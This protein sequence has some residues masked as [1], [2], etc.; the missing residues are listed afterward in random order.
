MD[1]AQREELAEL[2][3]EINLTSLNDQTIPI[4]TTTL[5]RLIELERLDADWNA[6]FRVQRLGESPFS[7]F[8]GP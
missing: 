5:R 6:R 2:R 1:N 4:S 7:T 3:R 8:W